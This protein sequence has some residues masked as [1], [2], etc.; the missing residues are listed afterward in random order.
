MQGGDRAHSEVLVNTSKQSY[1]KTLLL[2]CTGRGGGGRQG[3]AEVPMAVAVATITLGLLLKYTDRAAS[4]IHLG[5]K[6]SKPRG[7][8][9]RSQPANRGSVP[10]I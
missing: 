2:E 1:R 3:V 9:E 5:A 4:P 6:G 7:G 10:V 8:G